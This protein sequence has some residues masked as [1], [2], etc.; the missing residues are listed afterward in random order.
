MDSRT[1]LK[2]AL[3]HRLR[4]SFPV[5]FG[6]TPV[7][8]IHVLVIEK[9]R[10]HF[11]LET[12]PVKVT[13]PYQMLGEIEEDLL[14]QLGVDVIGISPPKNMFGQN[15]DGWKHFRTFWGQ[16]VLVPGEFLTK[17]NEKGDLLMYP[18][19]DTAGPGS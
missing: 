16:E 4:D 10:Q 11:G 7:T 15:Q 2:D 17:T 13:E 18:S 14:D 5:D 12:T 6:A 1:R 3:D 8:G 9:L 19:G